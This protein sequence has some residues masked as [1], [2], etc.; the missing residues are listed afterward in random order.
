[1]FLWLDAHRRSI[2]PQ[3]ERK[4]GLASQVTLHNLAGGTLKL[5]N[6]WAL[7]TQ[8]HRRNGTSTSGASRILDIT[9]SVHEIIDITA[10]NATNN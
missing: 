8:R 10:V 7:S 5:A 9:M 4:G 3:A 6:L 1:M 2:S